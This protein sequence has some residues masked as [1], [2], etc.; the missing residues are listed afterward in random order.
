MQRHLLREIQRRSLT[1]FY[2]GQVRNKS[3]MLMPKVLTLCLGQGLL[4]S[5][6]G[7][8]C[9]S[10][11]LWLAVIITSTPRV[12]G[13]VKWDNPWKV[14]T[15]VL[16]IWYVLNK[17]GRSTWEMH[18]CMQEAANTRRH[19]PREV[20][21]IQRPS[22]NEQQRGHICRENGLIGRRGPRTDWAGFQSVWGISHLNDWSQPTGEGPLLWMNMD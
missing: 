7:F 2:W 18:I 4:L 9:L 19:H 5:C 14:I 20:T 3:Q 11:S 1:S 10:P 22:P 8:G 12:V 21:G 17:C 15:I 13:R 16:S 6:W